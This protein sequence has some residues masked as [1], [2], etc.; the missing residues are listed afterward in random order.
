LLLATLVALACG[1]SSTPATTTPEPT[2]T[3]PAAVPSGDLAA[4]I[5]GS[6]R[7]DDER[8]RD[9]WRHPAETL[10]FFEV[11]PGKDVVELAPGGGWYTKLLAPLL[12]DSG[13]LTV[14]LPDGQY[15]D[16]FRQMQAEHPDLYGHVRVG[17]L[18]PPEAIE[19]GAPESADVV[20]T[21]RNTHGWV[22]NGVG[23]Q[24]MESVFRVLRPGGIFGVVQHRDPEG[25]T[26]DATRGYLPEATV[27]QLAVD[28]GFELVER[29][30]INANPAD[31]H[32]HPNGVW[33]LPPSLR[34][35]DEGREQFEAI[36]E[37]DRMTLKFR[38]PAAQ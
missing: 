19:L 23:P 35:G 37:S 17:R 15:G 33:S 29:S 36:G 34:G 14:G 11:A 5:A 16:T 12:R 2:E 24:V 21:F 13:S 25:A 31:T 27:I 18:A 20:L 22:R 26:A 7:T 38:K 28:A 8:A 9:V 4:A 32:E 30:E 1:G 3:A 10:A 6:H